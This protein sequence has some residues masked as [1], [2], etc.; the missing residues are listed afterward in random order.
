MRLS[1]IFA[2]YFPQNVQ[3]NYDSHS[4]TT[5]TIQAMHHVFCF[6]K[7]K[8]LNLGDNQRFMP[9][10]IYTFKT[11]LTKRQK[12]LKYI[13]FSSKVPPL[14][15]AKAKEG[16]KCGWTERLNSTS[17]NFSS[18]FASWPDT[19]PPPRREQT[20]IEKQKG[21]IKNQKFPIGNNYSS[22]KQAFLC[23]WEYSQI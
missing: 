3:K 22:N 4:C 5:K 21:K 8:G 2:I 12:I 9:R 17:T 1:A 6:Q 20:E 16:W 10:A 23:F 7:L 19:A 13:L 14:S 11:T 18:N 15:E